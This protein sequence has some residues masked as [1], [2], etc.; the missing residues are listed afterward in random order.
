MR[1]AASS[2]TNP[3]HV[4]GVAPAGWHIPSDAEWHTLLLHLDP[5]AVALPVSG[6]ESMIAANKLKESGTTHWTSVNPG[7]TNESGFTALP[8]GYRNDH[9]AFYTIGVNGNWWCSTQY[10]NDPEYAWHRSIGNSGSEVG[11]SSATKSRG[12]SVRCVKD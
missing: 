1:G 11:R 3:S 6:F 8:G 5:A 10:D 2:N 4:Q 7:A 9:G 12:F